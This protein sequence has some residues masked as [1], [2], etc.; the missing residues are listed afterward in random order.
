MTAYEKTVFEVVIT[1]YGMYF[2]TWIWKMH[3]CGT[4]KMSKNRLETVISQIWSNKSA[5]NY[6]IY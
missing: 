1:M 5:F 6:E 2:M 3:F 4:K